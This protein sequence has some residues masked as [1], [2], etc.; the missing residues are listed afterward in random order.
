M[1]VSMCVH[2]H[3]CVCEYVCMYVIYKEK[4]SFLD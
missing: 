1:Y 4:H 3:M 2:V